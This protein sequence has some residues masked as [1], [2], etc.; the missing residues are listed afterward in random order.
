MPDDV[1]SFDD[2]ERLYGDPAHPATD[3]RK[4]AAV[5]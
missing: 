3:P 2:F 5:S 1:P 4:G